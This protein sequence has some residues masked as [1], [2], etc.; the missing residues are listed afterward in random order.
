[1]IKS[2]RSYLSPTMYNII[3]KSFTIGVFPK[4]LKFAHV[5]PNFKSGDK[6]DPDNY[7]PISILSILSSFLKKSSYWLTLWFFSPTFTFWP[8]AIWNMKKFQFL[9]LYQKC[10]KLFTTAATTVSQFYLYFMISARHL[11]GLFKRLSY[12]N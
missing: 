6:P 10:C 7:R 11:I 12:I 9:M 8:I 1:M 5:K 2:I 4:F 3:N